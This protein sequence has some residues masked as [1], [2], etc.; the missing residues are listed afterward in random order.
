M[1]G[2]TKTKG[3]AENDPMA[4]QGAIGLSSGMDATP[5]PEPEITPEME[6]AGARALAEMAPDLA[7]GS[8]SARRALRQVFAAMFGAAA[9]ASPENPSLSLSAAQ[10]RS[11]VQEEMS[12]P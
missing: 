12:R 3:I 6:T 2:R 9:S 11:C 1:T 8:L 7:D 4:F 5:L 10:W